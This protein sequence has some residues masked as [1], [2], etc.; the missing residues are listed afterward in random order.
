AAVASWMRT[1]VASLDPTVPVTVESMTQRVS[2][3]EARPRFNATLLGIFA[4]MGIVLAAVGTYGVLAFLVVQR[5]QEIGIRMALGAHPRDVMKLILAQGAKL[6][7][8]GLLLGVAGAFALTRSMTALLF[9]VKAADPLIFSGVAL[10]LM[11]VALA[12]CYLPARRAMRVDPL[13]ALRYE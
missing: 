6:A 2:Q 9:G 5:T 4:A 12:A 13:V 10:F 1:T 7:I 11:V 3:L 8:A